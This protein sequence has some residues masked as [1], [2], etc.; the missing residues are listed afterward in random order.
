MKTSLIN[1]ILAFILLAFDAN[2]QELYMPRNIKQSYENGTRSMDGNPG[3]NYWQNG[4]KYDMDLT[5]TPD[6]KIVSGV[7]K[8]VYQTTAPILCACLPFVL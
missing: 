4:G 3:E 1:F 7:E 5:L 6:T 8:I 2:A